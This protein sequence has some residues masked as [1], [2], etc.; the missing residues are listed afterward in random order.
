MFE[1]KLFETDSYETSVA[2][3]LLEIK[4]D[5]DCLQTKLVAL[6]KLLTLKFMR[7]QLKHVQHVLSVENLKV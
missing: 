6:K 1:T 2:I 3:F 4:F 7:C 5:V